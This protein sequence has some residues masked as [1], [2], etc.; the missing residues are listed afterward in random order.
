MNRSWTQNLLQK[1]NEMNC[2][3]HLGTRSF[4]HQLLRNFWTA[5][6]RDW[7]GRVEEVLGFYK[8]TLTTMREN[9]CYK[10]KV[11][12]STCEDYL[13][14]PFPVQHKGLNE[15][16][17]SI[18]DDCTSVILFIKCYKWHLPNNC[19]IWPVS[20]TAS[21]FELPNGAGVPYRNFSRFHDCRV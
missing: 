14:N 5:E 6:Q 11:S 20:S 17:A 15:H 3:K 9:D 18:A 4:Q 7:Y 21:S 8:R 10:T 16:V 19:I 2:S 1:T 12:Q 13:V